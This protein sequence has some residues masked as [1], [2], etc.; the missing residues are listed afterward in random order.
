MQV[1]R[2]GPAL[3]EPA[4]ELVHDT[5]RQAAAKERAVRGEPL[6]VSRADACTSRTRESLTE[7]TNRDSGDALRR[8]GILNTNAMTSCPSFSANA[9]SAT[10]VNPR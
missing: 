8:C 4:H 5:S 2:P 1:D 6:D 9:A 10:R 3:S 7:A